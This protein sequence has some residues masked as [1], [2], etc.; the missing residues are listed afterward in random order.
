MNRLRWVWAA[1][2]LPVRVAAVV[3]V[4]GL[5]LFLLLAK[6]SSAVVQR[7]LVDALDSELAA[8]V[9]VAAPAVAVGDAAPQPAGGEIKVRVLDRAGTPV[10][11]SGPTPLSGWDVRRLLAGQ[12]AWTF[13]PAGMGPAGSAGRPPGDPTRWVGRVVS[14]PDGTPRLVVAGAESI[15]HAALVGRT[16]GALSVAAVLAALAMGAA[17]WVAARSALRPVARMRLAASALPAG[18][19]LPLPAARDE[20]R[21]LAEALNE[22]L[23]R[24][25]AA[26][27]RLCRF[28]GDA[29]HELRSPVAAIRAQAEVAVAH[30]DPDLAGATL[31]DVA[32][33]AGRLSALLDDL[34]ALARADAGERLPVEPVDVAEVARA[35]AHHLNQGELPVPGQVPGP[36]QVTVRV[37]APAP[38]VLSAAPS[39]V[40]RVLDNLLTNAV[41]HARRTVRVAVLPGADA[42]RILVD[43]DGAGVPAEHRARVF[44]RFYRVQDDRNRGSGGTGLGL[45]LVAETVRRYGGSAQVGDAPDGG[46]RF[47]VR[48]PGGR[49]SRATNP[50]PDPR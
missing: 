41:R 40:A 22:L 8:A 20:L 2:P 30:P 6:V 27:E 34:L 35:S 12:P 36:G 1:R 7:T 9:A 23:A 10:D 45:A 31:D 33:A 11:G 17:G 25:D 46:A 5:V 44:D 19:R 39:D 21:A 18:D 3:T 16:A 13:Q 43:D 29:A 50:P 14:A 28:T 26:A 24:R 42:V 49:S 4:V 15:A 32:A 37:T 38:A 48:W 47:E